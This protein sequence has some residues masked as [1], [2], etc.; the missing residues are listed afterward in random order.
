MYQPSRGAA[1]RLGPCLRAYQARPQGPD[2]VH[3]FTDPLP[4]PGLEL[5]CTPSF[6]GFTADPPP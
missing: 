3:S 6:G 4:F 5:F 2:M 1:R